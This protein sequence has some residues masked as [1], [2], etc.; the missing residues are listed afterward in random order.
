MSLNFK[1]FREVGSEQWLVLKNPIHRNFVR[2]FGPLGIHA[3]IRNAR[4]V[5]AIRRLKLPP[6]A[7]ILDAGCGHAYATFWLARHYPAYQFT[8]LEVDE[9]LVQDGE[10][11]AD[12]LGLSNVQFIQDNALNINQNAAYDLVFSIDVLEHIVNDIETLKIFRHALKPGGQLLLHLPRRHEEHRRFLAVFKNHTTPDHVRDEY[13]PDEIQGKL[14]QAGFTVDYLRYGFSMWGE[15]A[16]ELN[17]L[18]WG[19]RLL[20]NFFAL[21]FHPISVGLGYI[22]TRQDYDDGNSLL[23]LAHPTNSHGAMIE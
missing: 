22:D 21:V 9:A 4:V 11:I 23:V 10:Q 19:S 8:A 13:T 15:I 16:F 12:K 1:Q 5:N 3:R 6:N 2:L 18:F 7:R 20:R 17:Y 14:A